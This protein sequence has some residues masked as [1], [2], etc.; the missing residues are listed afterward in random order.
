MPIISINAAIITVIISIMVMI[1]IAATM[2]IVVI[3]IK[4]EEFNVASLLDAKKAVETVKGTMKTKLFI[5]NTMVIIQI[6][7]VVAMNS[8]KN[9]NHWRNY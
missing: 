6:I 8:S 5:V 3:T 1:A 4:V 7:K 9:F 2:I